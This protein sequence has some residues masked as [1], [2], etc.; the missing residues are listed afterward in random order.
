LFDMHRPGAALDYPKG[1]LGKV[2]DAL[3][4][5]VEQGSN[6]SKV[7][8]R[9]HV[10]SIDTTMDGCGI[11]G[12]TLRGGKKVMARE[13][14]IHNAPVWSLNNL[15]KNRHAKD[16][17]N[18]YLPQRC[19]RKPR[20]SWKLT[21]SGTYVMNDRESFETEDSLL[22]R[23]DTAEMTGS[24]LHLHLAIKAGGL[25]LDKMEAHYT[26]MDRSLAGSG[27]VDGPCGEL[28]MIA[29]SNPCVIDKTLVPEGYMVIHA[30]GA[31]NEP[32]HLWKDIKRNSP[33]YSRLKEERAEVLWRAVESIIP[34]VR[35]RV[36]L[37]LIGSPK[38]HERFLRRPNGTYGSATE[39]YLKDGSTPYKSLVLA[40]D[41]VFPG[42]GIPAVALSGAS[43]ANAFVSP[44]QQWRCLDTLKRDGL[45]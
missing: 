43:A 33:E 34:D 20:Q 23:T 42:I 32:Y 30:Y 9:R 25:D 41:G 12:L 24:F 17:L 13:G 38:T 37:E 39:D 15:I 4:K 11:T 21:E 44:L 3:V 27:P 29:V 40:G 19:I 10:E 18:N 16:V 31:G 1:G 26:V 36:V 8:L 22:F 7:N 28:N 35:G 2:I 45:I 5:G 6:G 14:V